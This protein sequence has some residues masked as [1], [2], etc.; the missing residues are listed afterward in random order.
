MELQEALLESNKATKDANGIPSA[1]NGENDEW[2][3][4]HR[5]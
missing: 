2:L 5:L 1:S 4:V 3:E